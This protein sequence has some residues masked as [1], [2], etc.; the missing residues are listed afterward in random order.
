[1]R[2]LELNWDMILVRGE[3]LRIDL[4]ADSTL[5]E[6]RRFDLGR[7]LRE[8]RQFE[9]LTL[10]DLS[11]SSGISV[12]QLSRIERGQAPHSRAFDDV[13]ADRTVP[14]EFRR[15]RFRH[16]ELHRLATLVG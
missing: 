6:N 10:R 4:S 12:A 16:P 7:D 15:A 5:W 3:T 8:G 11:E 14:R 9:N 13:E 1:M 2:E